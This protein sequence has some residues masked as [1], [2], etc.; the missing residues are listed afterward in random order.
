MFPYFYWDSTMILLLPALILAF[1]AQAKVSSTFE[2]YLRVPARNGLT[3]AEVAREI[4]RLSGIHDVSVEIQGGRLSDY[5]DP[6]RKVLKL[7]SDVYN[8]RSLAAQGVA[9]HECGHAIQHDVGYAPLA[10]RN[11]IVP[12]ASFGSQ[13]AFPLFFLGLFLRGEFLM[14]L[15]ILLFSA[16]VLFQLITLPVEY[17]ASSRAVTVLE[18][19][20]FIDRDEA[21]PVRKVLGAAALTYVAA[22]LMA[23]MQLLRLLALAGIYRD[24]R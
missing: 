6:R 8:G 18:G 9:A 19:H 2:R 3:G 24:D 12:V 7:S 22:T 5:Y 11:S 4:L 13:L 10:I 23:V 14:T 16:A 20:G 21:R 1:Y 15:G 17:N